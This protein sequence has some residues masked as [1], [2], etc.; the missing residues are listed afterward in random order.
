MVKN[1]LKHFKKICKHKYWVAHYCFKCG[2]Y[3]RGIKHDM[4]KFSP[5]EFWESVKYYQGDRSPIDAAKEDKGWSAAWMHHKGRNTH[6][7]EYWQDNFD[8]GGNPLIMPFE[9]S[10]EMLCDYLAAGRAYMGE[11]FSFTSE[12]KWWA[13]KN[14]KPLAMHPVNNHFIS[15]VLHKLWTIE[16]NGMLQTVDRIL[17]EIELRII[18]EDCINGYNKQQTNN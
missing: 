15:R 18:Y 14:N 13:A 10:C 17:N 7:Y 6:H 12:W 5:I 8:N 11:N 3:W 9:D 1:S 2:L 4:S 16:T